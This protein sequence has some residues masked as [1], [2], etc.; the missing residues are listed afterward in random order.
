V[1]V[2]VNGDVFSCFIFRLP[3]SSRK[4][5]SSPAATRVFCL[6]RLCPSRREMP[7]GSCRMSEITVCINMI[8]R[9]YPSYGYGHCEFSTFGV[10]LHEESCTTCLKRGKSNGTAGTCAT[11][12][13]VAND[14]QRIEESPD[15]NLISVN[16]NVR[17]GD[18]EKSPLSCYI[19]LEPFRV[20]EKVSFSIN[21]RCSHAFHHDCI[22]GC[23]AQHDDS[24]CPTC[25][26]GSIL[27]LSP[28]MK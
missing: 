21:K 6:G 23:L 11:A 7:D 3:T 17:G 19:C 4:S 24:I 22:V 15:G 13:L 16:E 18:G 14:D 2:L 8:S 5:A 20:D 9:L 26:G 1:I 12:G 10:T 28:M 25:W 27:A